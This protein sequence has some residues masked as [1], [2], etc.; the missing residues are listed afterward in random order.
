MGSAHEDLDLAVRKAY[1]AKKTA[2]P[3]RFLF[4]LNQKLADLEAK[5]EPIVG[6]GLPE[7]H[8]KNSSLRSDDCIRME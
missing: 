7:D 1:G 8:W 4:E 6:P 2:D 3:L 5:G